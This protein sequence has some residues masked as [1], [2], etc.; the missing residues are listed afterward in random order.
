MGIVWKEYSKFQQERNKNKTA[1]KIYLRALVGEGGGKV[2]AVTNVEE[3]DMLWQEF[4]SMMKRLNNDDGLTMQQL[5]D[6]VLSEHTPITQTKVK[7]EPVENMGGGTQ[8][9]NTPSA[10]IGNPAK[11][12][13]LDVSESLYRAPEAPVVSASTI[14]ATSLELY[15][16]AK[17]MPA[18][19]TAE[20][21]A[22]DG[23]TPPSRPD[24][25]FNPSPPRL[26]DPSGSDLLGTDISLKLIRLLIGGADDNLTGSA[27]LDICKGCWT[28]SAL[29]EREAIKCTEALDKKLVSVPRVDHFAKMKLLC[30]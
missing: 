12:V 10:E 20:W 4:L 29:K 13:K 16:R 8:T 1:Q 30:I 26:S 23:D 9:L 7:A 14:E 17:Y 2:G 24:P 22:K 11:R 5:K 21:L 18:E 25:L 27:I 28:M 15:G 19:I 3:Q 6:A